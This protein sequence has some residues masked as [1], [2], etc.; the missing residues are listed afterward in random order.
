MFERPMNQTAEQSKFEKAVTALLFILTAVIGWMPFFYATWREPF[1]IPSF[2]FAAAALGIL[3]AA[4]IY[5]AAERL[6]GIGKG[7]YAAAIVFSFAPLG[8]ALADS[9]LLP[10]TMLIFAAS[11]I[12]S[13]A[14]RA[15]GRNRGFNL[16]IIGG[17]LLI[18]GYLFSFFAACLVF[19]FG[20]WL[21][22]RD[23][24]RKLMLCG[25][26]AICYFLGSLLRNVADIGLPLIL[27][28]PK[29]EDL[30]IVKAILLQLP[31]L[32]WLIPLLI[33]IPKERKL[34]PAWQI[35]AALVSIATYCVTAALDMDLMVASAA[36]APILAI[37]VTDLCA[38]WFAMKR[39]ENQI[40][41]ALPVLLS[42]IAMLLLVGLRSSTGRRL[43]RLCFFLHLRLFL[44][45]VNYRAGILRLRW[46][47]DFWQ[48][49][50][51]GRGPHCW[52]WRIRSNRAL[53]HNRHLFLF[54]P[55]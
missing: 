28:I 44:R 42:A 34:L 52:K 40:V 6:I 8:A 29:P 51:G 18:M 25:A 36:A 2:L 23:S 12:N 48:D 33:L 46:A 43:L 4:L 24:S 1:A 31:W 53:N 30:H 3:S 41:F 47:W 10:I 20:V 39:R 27:G 37:S 35:G 55:S 50:C 17:L 54:S 19:V 22:L 14:V 9:A 13:L 38:R 45:Y 11:A 32:F 21:A 49:R 26:L 16:V 5:D 7:I 15:Q